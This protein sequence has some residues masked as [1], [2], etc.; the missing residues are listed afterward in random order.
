MCGGE[1]HLP[2]TVGLGN[3]SNDAVSDT[4]AAT[5]FGVGGGVVG[6]LLSRD[7]GSDSEGVH[8][9]CKLLE[10]IR[11]RVV[12]DDVSG[13]ASSFALGYP[14]ISFQGEFERSLE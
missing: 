8:C 3:L 2:G 5:V 10:V 12:T 6:R 4:V 1:S 7:D 14:F 13:K 9:E 11:R